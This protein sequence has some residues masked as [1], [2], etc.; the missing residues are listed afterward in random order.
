M[1][2]ILLRHPGAAAPWHSA[3]IEA[4]LRRDYGPWPELWAEA[5]SL[6]RAA[7]AAG[8]AAADERDWTAATLPSYRVVAPD[9]RPERHRDP[10]AGTVLRWLHAAGW[11]SYQIMRFERH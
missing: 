6:R 2:D 4:A 10:D 7:A 5:A 8:L 3:T 1:S 9:D 11:L